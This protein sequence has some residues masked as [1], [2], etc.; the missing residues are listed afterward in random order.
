MPITRHKEDCREACNV[1]Q[2]AITLWSR[3][4]TPVHIAEYLKELGAAS[5]ALFDGSNVHHGS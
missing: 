5:T 2:V 1:V 3:L 4:F